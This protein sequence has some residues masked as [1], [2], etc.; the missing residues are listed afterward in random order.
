M[1]AAETLEQTSA[2]E[3]SAYSEGTFEI[4]P[5]QGT[6]EHVVMML[7]DPVFQDLCSDPSKG[8]WDSMQHFIVE[9]RKVLTA[10]QTEECARRV[11]AGLYERVEGYV[12]GE[13]FTTTAKN[14]NEFQSYFIEN[15]EA[16]E[17][18]FPPS[19]YPEMY[20]LRDFIEL[21]AAEART[22]GNPR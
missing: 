14:R 21:L 9:G 13:P 8:D 4:E 22:R 1:Q 16:R 6:L 19:D 3:D 2:V 15:G 17:V 20:S 11:E 12:P 10:F 7:D 18:R 5:G